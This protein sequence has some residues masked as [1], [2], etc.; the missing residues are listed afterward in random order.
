MEDNHELKSVEE[1]EEGVWVWTCTCGDT[2][3][4]SRAYRGEDLKRK[5][6]GNHRG[7]ARRRAAGKRRPR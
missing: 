1:T 2:G 7:H 5:A 3:W 6:K 4:T